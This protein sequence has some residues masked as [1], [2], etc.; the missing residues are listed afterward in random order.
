MKKVTKNGGKIIMSL[1]ETVLGILLFINP[2]G[3]TATI[4]KAVGILLM[5]AGIVSAVRYFRTDPAEAHLEQGLA[6]ALCALAAGAFCFFK[7]EWFVVT[8][9]IV[10]IL[11]GLA[12]LFTGIIR[13]QW[14]VDMLRMKTGRWYLPGLGALLSLIFGALIVLNPFALTEFLWTFVAVSV[15]VNAI[16]DL[17]VALFAHSERERP[18]AE[19]E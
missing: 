9:R 8:F 17:C 6:K 19:T 12:I 4:I 5:L 10:T 3:F 1:C 16:I 15:I 13:I 2:L 11:Y 14:T 18:E 7:T